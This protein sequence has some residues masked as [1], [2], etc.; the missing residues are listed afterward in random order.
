M[1]VVCPLKNFVE[2]FP[3]IGPYTPWKEPLADISKHSNPLPQQASVLEWP[4][5]QIWWTL[6]IGTSGCPILKMKLRVKPSA[7]VPK[8]YYKKVGLY[9]S[10]DLL[11]LGRASLAFTYREPALVYPKPH[12]ASLW[13]GEG[14]NGK[15]RG[16]RKEVGRQGGPPGGGGTDSQTVAFALH[17]PAPPRRSQGARLLGELEGSGANLETEEASERKRS[18]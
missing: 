6:V 4:L 13:W 1:T 14:R 12:R 18:N 8:V 11:G 17:L 3:C 5:D 16:R 15:G 9:R 7:L 2:T 10:R